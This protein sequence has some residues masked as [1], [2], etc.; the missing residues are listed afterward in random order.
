M[1]YVVSRGLPGVCR[2]TSEIKIIE[3]EIAQTLINYSNYGVSVLSPI[4]FEVIK[5]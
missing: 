5:V 2:V 4:E 1:L 3:L